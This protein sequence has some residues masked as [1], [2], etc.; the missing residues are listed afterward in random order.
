MNQLIKVTG[1]INFS[2]VRFL[3]S[4]SPQYHEKVLVRESIIKSLFEDNQPPHVI[5]NSLISRPWTLP[6]KQSS[7]ILSQYFHHRKKGSNL[8]TTILLTYSVGGGRVIELREVDL[9]VAKEVAYIKIHTDDSYWH[10]IYTQVTAVSP[11]FFSM[12]NSHIVGHAEYEGNVLCSPLYV[13]KRINSITDTDY[14]PRHNRLLDTTHLATS[15]GQ[16]EMIDVVSRLITGINWLERAFTDRVYYHRE[17]VSGNHHT[18][19]QM[20]LFPDRTKLVIVRRMYNYRH[21]EPMHE[22]IGVSRYNDTVR[23]FLNKIGVTYDFSKSVFTST[24]N[25]I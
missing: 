13:D 23:E 18:E 16:F 8:V 21:E 6:A 2:L 9:T 12:E 14:E 4:S 1:D 17:V 15:D 24:S 11:A 19:I 20:F 22:W 25:Y 3:L 10:H 5:L 7:N